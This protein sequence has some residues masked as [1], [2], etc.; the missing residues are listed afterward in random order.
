MDIKDFFREPTKLTK[1][2]VSDRFKDKD[3]NKI[4]FEIMPIDENKNEQIKLQCERI[5][6]N[7]K[8]FDDNLYITKLVCECV[9]SP[10]L[11]SSELQTNY[12]VLGREKLIKSMLYAGEFSN[13]VKYVE[14]IC[15][16]NSDILEDIKKIKN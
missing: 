5:S 3:G 13:L 9:V 14:E 1:V 7:E 6:G 16:F 11:D 4:P 15:G 10:D 8:V 12:N 2:V